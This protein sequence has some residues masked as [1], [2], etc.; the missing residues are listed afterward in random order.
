MAVGLS[1]ASSTP[2]W[3]FFN[4][5]LSYPSSLGDCIH[6]RIHGRTQQR[7]VFCPVPQTV[8]FNNASYSPGSC[9]QQCIISLFRGGLCSTTRYHILVP[10]VVALQQC[11]VISARPFSSTHRYIPVPSAPVSLGGCSSTMCCHPQFP[12]AIVHPTM[13]HLPGLIPWRLY[14]PMRR[15]ILPHGGCSVAWHICKNVLSPTTCHHI[16][17]PLAV[18]LINASLVLFQVLF[19]DGRF[20]V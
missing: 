8:V 12:S 2:W 15:F 9:I 19:P 6:G 20:I 7:F 4:N 14:S 13:C 18:V 1:N 3:L 11:I 5:A 17:V 10:K 16:L